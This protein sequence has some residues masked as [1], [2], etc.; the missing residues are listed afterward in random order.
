MS[1]NAK[2]P[3]EAH[4]WKHV[5]DTWIETITLTHQDPVFGKVMHRNQLLEKLLKADK[6]IDSITKGLNS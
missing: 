2:L 3:S 4:D 5:N 6:L 1:I